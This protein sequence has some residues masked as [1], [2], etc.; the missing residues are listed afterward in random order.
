MK[1]VMKTAMTAG[2]IWLWMASW[3]APFF[4]LGYFTATPYFTKTAK[5]VVP[6]LMKISNM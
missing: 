3:C 1:N 4:A 5:Y 6:V 2:V